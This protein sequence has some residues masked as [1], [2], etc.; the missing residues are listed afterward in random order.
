MEK[1]AAEGQEGGPPKSPAPKPEEKQ[2]EEGP[3]FKAFS[4][5]GRTLRG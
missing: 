3:R 5:K 2:E 1:K 4:G